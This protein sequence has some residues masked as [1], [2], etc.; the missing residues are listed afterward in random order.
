MPYLTWLVSRRHGKT[1]V[2]TETMGLGV[3]VS[4]ARL[5]RSR[6]LLVSSIQAWAYTNTSNIIVMPKGCEIR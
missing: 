2:L 6:F 3:G 5:D 4:Q 1:R